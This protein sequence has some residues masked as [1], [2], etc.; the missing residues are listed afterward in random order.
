MAE[1]AINATGWHYGVVTYPP[2]N[3]KNFNGVFSATDYVDNNLQIVSSSGAIV[4]AMNFSLAGSDARFKD[5]IKPYSLS[6][7]FYIC[8]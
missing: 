2:N 6:V 4:G 8:Y 1:E 3:Y 7:K 5:H